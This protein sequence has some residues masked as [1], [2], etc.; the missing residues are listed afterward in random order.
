MSMGTYSVWTVVALSCWLLSAAEVVRLAALRD[1]L[2]R[3][4]RLRVIPWRGR[5][6]SAWG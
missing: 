5:V 3:V 1:M 6:C 2:V 4:H